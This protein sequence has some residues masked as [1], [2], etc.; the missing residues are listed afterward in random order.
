MDAANMH[1]LERILELA[2][3]VAYE[4]DAEDESRGI[5][6]HYFGSHVGGGYNKKKIHEETV[7]HP[8]NVSLIG[9]SHKHYFKDE[10]GNV[11]ETCTTDSDCEARNFICGVN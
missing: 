8:E 5:A 9:N 1:E 11:L 4:R 6:P 2:D 7:N 10:N 3:L